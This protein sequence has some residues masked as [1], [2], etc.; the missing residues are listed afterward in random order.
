LAA[1]ACAI[2]LLAAVVPY[3]SALAGATASR[4]ALKGRTVTA[5]FESSDPSDP[6]CIE[7]F[8]TV[9][10]SDE[11]VRISPGEAT[12]TVGA[13]LVVRQTDVCEDRAVFAGAG[14]LNATDPSFDFQIANNLS[15][16]TL[17]ATV[18]VLD[19][20][21]DEFYEFDVDL[22]WTATGRAVRE[23]FHEQLRDREAGIF[24][25]SQ[26]R[27]RHAPAE[28]TGTVFGL[29]RN[30]APDPSTSAEMFSENTGTVFVER[31]F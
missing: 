7:N 6:D 17:T 20:L 19:A 13:A 2:A 15:S 31:S 10:A 16:A 24:V 11:M 22:A 9:L 23:H 3:G 5:T 12:A 25:N 1:G 14:D 29:D 21:T 30:F 27:G 8:V 4:F 28:A 18:L 26:V